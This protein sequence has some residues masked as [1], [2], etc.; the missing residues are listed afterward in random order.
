M[1]ELP[2]EDDDR[3]MHRLAVSLLRGLGDVDM[4]DGL[5]PALFATRHVLNWEVGRDPRP[6]EIEAFA[7][8][9]PAW[10]TIDAVCDGIRPIWYEDGLPFVEHAGMEQPLIPLCLAFLDDY[11]RL[12]LEDEDAVEGRAKGAAVRPAERRALRS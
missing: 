9:F 5:M 7:H 11:A 2:E 4:S 10:G 12:R 3:Y 6:A 1:V 8:D